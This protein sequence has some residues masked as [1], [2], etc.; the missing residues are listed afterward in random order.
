M[1]IGQNNHALNEERAREI[2]EEVE[3]GQSTKASRCFMW[4]VAAVKS[5]RL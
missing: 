2:D 5:V 1:Q 3:R 4:V